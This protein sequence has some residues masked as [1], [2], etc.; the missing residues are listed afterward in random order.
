MDD[1]VIN[2]R[3]TIPG[4][5]IEESFSRSGGPGGQNVNKVASK[6]E[7]RWR[8]ADSEAV[9]ELSPG[10]R[11]WLLNRL[12]SRLTAGG[13]LLVISQKTR[14]QGK[15]REDAAAKLIDIVRIAMTRPK[16]RRATRPSRGSRE[17]RLQGKKQRGAIK[18]S[19]RRPEHD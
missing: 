6:V 19:R 2:A 15:N 4:R 7:L 5:E 17:R 12:A 13:D 8:P 16:A 18:R 1:L 14:E 11:E 9:A 10:T 3:L